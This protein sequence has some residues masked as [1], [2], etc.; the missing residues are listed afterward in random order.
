MCT[1]PNVRYIPY[2]KFDAY[3]THNENK[4]ISSAEVTQ[5]MQILSDRASCKTDAKVLTIPYKLNLY[6]PLPRKFGST[7]LNFPA[8]MC[9]LS[10]SD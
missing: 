6:Y 7:N 10:N 1:Y 2:L 8:Q 5:V 9:N 3:S 4:I